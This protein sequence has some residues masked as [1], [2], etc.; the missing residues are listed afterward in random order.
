MQ[1]VS[2]L[3]YWWQSPC[4]VLSNF[5]GRYM[6]AAW[7][8][9][10]MPAIF[11]ESLKMHGNAKMYDAKHGKCFAPSALFVLSQETHLNLASKMNAILKS[12]GKWISLY[13]AILSKCWLMF[14]GLTFTSE[15][16]NAPNSTAYRELRKARI[17]PKRYTKSCLLRGEITDSFLQNTVTWRSFV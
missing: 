17:Q 8:Y 15:F 12:Q 11:C 7:T 6:Y 9:F 13:V 4:Q 5:H 1:K 14:R 2:H 3:G 10:S 16:W